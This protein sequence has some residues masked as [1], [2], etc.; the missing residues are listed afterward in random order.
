MESV[1]VRRL[2]RLSLLWASLLGTPSCT[3]NGDEF[4]K[5]MN[6]GKAYLENRNFAKAIDM[7]DEA[8]EINPNSTAALRNLARAH[9]LSNLP[10]AH[11]SA[12]DALR[13]GSEREAHSAATSYLMGLTYKRM[14]RFE[15]AVAHFGQAV[16]LDPE[17]PTL[18]FQLANACQATERHDEAVIQLRET[19]RLDPLHASAYYKLAIYARKASDQ[20]EYQRL[21]R[22]FM[23]LRKLLDPPSSADALERCVHLVPEAAA[24]KSS[25][26]AGQDAVPAI[27][28]QF[29]DVTEGVF[30]NESG[31]NAVAVAVIEVDNKGRCTLFSCDANGGLGLLKMLPTGKFE[32]TK[33]ELQ[34]PA[35]AALGSCIV[36]NCHD[37]V[38]K[39]TKYDPS[40]HA[41]NDVFLI[42]ARSA[43][44]LKRHGPLTFED[45]TKTAGLDRLTGR[46]ARWVDYE[47]DGD[48]DLLIARATGLELWQ[49]NGYPDT[50]LISGEDATVLFGKR[51]E[52]HR[53]DLP[54]FEFRTF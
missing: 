18:R 1:T 40:Q 38:P 11:E 45:T 12:L 49:N 23:R 10:H 48:L 43:Y 9:L 35:N 15:D 19:I 13:R 29:T 42:G 44:L 20:K 24:I 16:Q 22:E 21:L 51:A 7:L 53:F 3:D 4:V 36:G 31:I 41:R 6:R 52:R 39:G 17:T 5:L 8:I 28:V 54:K 33:I 37:D 34:L 14:S 50:A 2:T 32:H 26:A 47:H 46:R 27:A 30:T 25:P